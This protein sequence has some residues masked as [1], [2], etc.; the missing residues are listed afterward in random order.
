MSGRAGTNAAA[1]ETATLAA[2]ADRDPTDS[3]M[4]NADGLASS[5]GSDTNAA[6]AETSMPAA[7]ASGNPTN[8]IMRNADEPASSGPPA[9]NA[10]EIAPQSP[11]GRVPD[12]RFDCDPALCAIRHPSGHIVA[13]TADTSAA[14]SACNYAA[15]IVIDDATAE[16][17][18][19]NPAVAIMTKRELARHGSA[20]I[21][22]A[23]PASKPEI[24][25]AVAEPY[26]P[27]HAQRRF[28]RAARGMPPYQRK[29][30]PPATE[31]AK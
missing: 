18:C 4:Q 19:G 25:H 23:A 12:V 30:K 17:S 24:R 6:A 29:A 20:A 14:R 31:S 28:S 21:Y 3:S 11:V 2:T 27:W 22:F 10:A 16:L 15:L 8:P 1:V 13:H 26:R 7:T 5:G 9:E